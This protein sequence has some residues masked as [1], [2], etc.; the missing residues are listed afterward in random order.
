MNIPPRAS[1]Q[2]LRLQAYPIGSITGSAP[3]DQR[4][5][6]VGLL[7]VIS[8]LLS[9]ANLYPWTN[10]SPLEVLW[11]TLLLG[12]PEQEHLAPLRIGAL[13]GIWL[14]IEC[15]QSVRKQVKSGH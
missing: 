6:A 5:S 11:R 14:L 2:R 1:G 8:M 10:Q 3:Y 12:T 9:M 15:V 7:R 13:T 4:A